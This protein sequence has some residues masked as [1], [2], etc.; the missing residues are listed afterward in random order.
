MSLSSILDQAKDITSRLAPPTLARP[1]DVPRLLS[2][3]LENDVQT[4]L[5]TVVHAMSTGKDA[6]HYFPHVIKNVSA[7]SLRT[8]RLVYCYL[9]RFCAQNPDLLLLCVNLIQKSLSSLSPSAR[10]LALR[11]MLLVRTPAILPICVLAVKAASGDQAAVVRAACAQAAGSIYSLALQEGDSSAQTSIIQICERL[12][13]DPS[14]SVVGAAVV[15]VARAEP[16]KPIHRLFRH[17][18]RLLQLLEP[19]AQ[20]VAVAL[21]T[22]YARQNLPRPTI[23]DRAQDTEIPMPDDERSLGVFPAYDVYFHPDLETFLHALRGACHSSNEALILATARAFAALAPTRTLRDFRIDALLTRGLGSLSEPDLVLRLQVILH[24]ARTKDA[25]LFQNR[26]RVF[27]LSPSDSL[28]VARLRLAVL[29]LI[30][31]ENNVGKIVYEL[32]HCATTSDEVAAETVRAAGRCLQISSVWAR[33]VLRWLMRTASKS[34]VSPAVRDACLEVARFLVQQSPEDHVKAL[35]SLGSLACSDSGLGAQARAAAVWLVGEHAE[36]VPKLVPDLARVLIKNFAEEEPIMREHILLLSAKFLVGELEKPSGQQDY[37]R[38]LFNYAVELCKYDSVYDVR[39]RARLLELLL[40]QERTELARLFLKAPKSVPLLLLTAQPVVDN[41]AAP[42]SQPAGGE[43]SPQPLNKN[44]FSETQKT[45]DLQDIVGRCGVVDSTSEFD[46]LIFTSL[47][48]FM[49]IPPW[50]NNVPPDL[51]R[52]SVQNTAPVRSVSSNNQYNG[53]VGRHAMSSEVVPIAPKPK[54]K[55]KAQSLDDFLNS[56]ETSDALRRNKKYLKE[57]KS[58]SD[59]E[60]GDTEK[61]GSATE[62]ESD[63]SDDA[64]EETRMI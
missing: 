32:Q 61:S 44:L 34:T 41:F 28:A 10:A 56:S 23:I 62:S 11:A 18:C 50:T 53:H 22:N 42:D 31:N 21:M 6:S 30:V 63:E 4:G 12:L 16:S 24:I 60:S 57:S 29:A 40:S 3:S 8:R 15:A 1:Q 51:V 27:F 47:S 54:S 46:G 38:K 19:Y 13:L 39:D 9:E 26:F 2:S 52:D 43:V 17:L 20:A 55:Y 58:D 5:R 25:V 14:P 7:L 37:A 36:L 49:K 33:R 59:S 35:A 45:A 48:E 64:D